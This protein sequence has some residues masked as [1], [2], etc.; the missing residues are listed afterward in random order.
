VPG[1]RE[2]NQ[3]NGFRIPFRL[4]AR[5]AVDT[6]RHP[7]WFAG[8]VSNYLA[9][10]G[11]PRHE[12]HPE[13]YRTSILGHGA[14]GSRTDSVTWEEIRRLRNTWSRDFIVK[15]RLT[16]ADAEQAVLVGAD[17]VVVSNH[18]GRHLDSA[19]HDR[20]VADV[21]E[22]VNGG[23]TVILGSG[24]RRGSDIAKAIAL[25]AKA[26]LVGRATLYGVSVAGEAG[27][28]KALAILREELDR[29]DGLP[30]LRE[31]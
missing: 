4:S 27:A 23:C 22:A 3:R 9:T 25:G 17:G 26:V 19:G 12:N 21:A 7:R 13:W 11:M 18:G 15:G 5:A 30:R 8:V 28:A 2:C 20:E 14:H 10:T 24:I 6:A 16:P 29:N 31:H 1:K